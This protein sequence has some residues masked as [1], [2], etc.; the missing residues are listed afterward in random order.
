[1]KNNVVEFK[2]TKF[3]YFGPNGARV[4]FANDPRLNYNGRPGN[5]GWAW[6]V[7][8]D[9]ETALWL[10]DQGVSV[11]SFMRMN[12]DSGD[13]ETT[14]EVKVNV[15]FESKFGGPIIHWYP[16]DR[17]EILLTAQSVQEDH[18]SRAAALTEVA[19]RGA[20][21]DVSC[22]CSFYKNKTD[23]SKQSLFLMFMEAVQRNM[24][25]DPY[26]RRREDTNA[27]PNAD[28]VEPNDPNDM[29]F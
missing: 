15:N 2:H 14:Y 1:M 18:Y 10:I 19:N 9:E 12:R 29:P 16:D 20:I 8:P 7:I 28:M 21:E 6:I 27:A 23:P 13:N 26:D 17:H 24:M 4:N 25:A 3:C 22:T 11:R 5:Y